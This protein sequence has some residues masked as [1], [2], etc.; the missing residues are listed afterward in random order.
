MGRAA[1]AP[2]AKGTPALSN[3]AK[4]LRAPQQ[5]G[6]RN[7]P[8]IQHMQRLFTVTVLI[9][10]LAG[11]GGSSSSSSAMP[12]APTKV[13]FVDGAPEL[14]VYAN[15]ALQT[16]GVAYLQVNSQ[17]VVSIFSYGSFSSFLPIA[18]G[19]HSLFARNTQGYVVGP[20]TTPALSPGKRYTLIVVGSYPHYRVLAFEEP[21]FSDTAAISLYEASPSV[22]QTTFG[23]F[24][25]S[26]ATNFRQLGSARFGNLATASLGKSVS[27]I[28]GYVGSSSKPLGTITPVQA[29]PFDSNN[30]L[31]FQKASRLSLFLFDARSKS[32]T[33]S[34]PVFGSLDQ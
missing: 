4:R 10:A 9:F 1:A 20:L 14:Q 7:G 5:C 12:A 29:N 21:P 2:A 3:T 6:A 13:R 11:C 28:G 15:G 25:A 24:E 23:R 26:T 34:G 22:P 32:G 27:N 31:P 8:H 17:T 30:V 19:A 16:L 18:P 33:A